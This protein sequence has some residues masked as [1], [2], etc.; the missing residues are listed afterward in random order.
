MVDCPVSKS[1]D[2]FALITALTLV[3]L[4]VLLLTSMVALVRTQQRTNELDLASME[5]R[6]NAY[7]A[8][9]IAVAALQKHAGPDQRIT[10]PATAVLPSKTVNQGSGPL[11]DDGAFGYRS[12]ARTSNSRSYLAS[13]ETY[14]T[15]DERAAWDSAV[16]DW[17]NDNDFQP[18][19]TA[20]F[21]SGRR[22]DRATDPL[23]DPVA[24]PDER[25]EAGGVTRY[26]AFNRDQPPVWLVSG[27][28]RLGYDP[29]TDTDHPN[30]YRTPDSTIPDPGTDAANPTV[31][32]VGDASATR[33]RD[34]HDGLDGRVKVP[35]VDIP[36]GEAGDRTGRY[37]FWVGDESIKANF[38]VHAEDPSGLGTGSPAYRN[39]LQVP[40]R[41][42]WERMEGFA[43][44]NLDPYADT[45]R[46]VRAREHIRMLDTGFGDDP[47]TPAVNE[48]V[49]ARNFHAI[50]AH[51]QSLL[52]DAALGGL[53]RDLTRYL[54][55]GD[56]LNDD[57]PIAD[58]GR[59]T[60][61]DPRFAAWGGNNNGF[62]NSTDA[63]LDGI[64][65]WGR[66]REWFQ[67]EAT[68]GGSIAPDADSGVGPVI[69]Y[70][71][72]N[73]GWSY[74]G[75]SQTIRWHWMP[76]VVLW[77]PYDV[78]L[79]Q[80][81][82]D[83]DLRINPILT[84]TLV[85]NPDPALADVQT[86]TG[87]GWQ[88]DPDPSIDANGDGDPANDW[89]FT[90]T[91]NNPGQPRL[92]A[93]NPDATDVSNGPWVA[94]ADPADG[95]TDAYGRLYYA[96][97]VA[98]PATMWGDNRPI[99][100]NPPFGPLG[101]RAFALRFVPH[102]P[103]PETRSGDGEI[104]RV[105]QLR[106]NAGFEAGQAK[107]FTLAS[108]GEWVPGSRQA[109]VNDFDP[110]FPVDTWFDVIRVMDGPPSAEAAG[111]RWFA[112]DLAGNRGQ[113]APAVRLA[114]AGGGTLFFTR[115]FGN[116]ETDDAW[117]AAQGRDYREVAG[118][119]PE[120]NADADGD[121]I[122][123][124]DENNPK[125]V[126][127]WRPL[128]DFA[129]FENHLDTQ[130]GSRRLAANWAYG[131]T[132]LQPLTGDGDA[133]EEEVHHYQ[134][135]LSRFNYAAAFY[136]EHPLVEAMRSRNDENNYEASGIYASGNRGN[137]GLI[138]LMTVQ[139]KDDEQFGNFNE[140]KWDENQADFTDGF[141]LITFQN[142]EF[143]AGSS[144]IGL[145]RIAVRN[146][147][148][149]ESNLLSLGQLQQVNLS[150]Y[151]WQPAN[152]IG[153]SWASPYVDRE[154]IAGLH[155]RPVGTQNSGS[156][157]Q[158]W[159]I[160]FPGPGTIAN[161]ARGDGRPH[162]PGSGSQMEEDPVTGIVSYISGNGQRAN[163]FTPGNTL[164]DLSYLLNENLW[165]RYFLSA[166]PASPDPR[167]ALPNGRLRYTPAAANA[168]PGDLA[169]FETAAA[170]LRNVGALNVNA[171]SVE[172]WKALL[173]AFRDLSLANNPADTVPVVRSLDPIGEPITFTFDAER[174]AT[175]EANEI[176]AVPAGK[177]YTRVMSGFRYLS[178]GMI[179]ALAERIV[180]EVRL[181]GPFYS[182]ADFVNR[183]LVPPDGSNTPGSDWYAA[184]THGNVGGI[185]DNHPDFISGGYRP[186]IGLQG[187]SGTLQRA[188]QVSGING[189]LNHPRFSD[190]DWVYTPR[191]KSSG[192]MDHQD[193]HFSANGITGNL[194]PKHT[195]MPSMRSHVDT[196]HLAGAPVGE[197]GQLFDGAPGF[198]TQGDLL[199]MLA[200][201]LTPRGDTFLVRTYG[202]S[203]NP[204]TGEIRSRAW[205]E[206]VVQRVARPVTPAA[207]SGPDRW[208]YTDRFGR[209][210]EI[211]EIRWL[212]RDE[213]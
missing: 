133:D 27:N 130:N 49:T 166:G 71:M 21:D 121:G 59:Y 16:K 37:G 6:A 25:Y 101:D 65:S 7:L 134:A 116:L 14:L 154:A 137:E 30:G 132:W 89:L 36:P 8:L 207:A 46:R 135:V 200:P 120:G 188:I 110:D 53:R 24:L 35:L 17:W 139:H 62:P 47:T 29:L 129:S 208:R 145:D 9:K 190:A 202:D 45:F 79:D 3:G 33:A 95:L 67:N 169:G 94:D 99:S 106:I 48:S 13:A 70:V 11:Y 81:A 82:Y 124:R 161:N 156:T 66:I 199:A 172:A 58:P 126:P 38:A 85:V 196:E 209:Q 122:V 34:S 112:Q 115:K 204:A 148:R 175:I 63:A 96:L 201:A 68:G 195:Q 179:Q 206:A 131:R 22:Q 141:A 61:N 181:R 173:T 90:D 18:H 192:G 75:P 44:A 174:N 157:D 1:R 163:F 86:Q 150:A 138:K 74:H 164:L 158:P 170:Y 51:S 54:E 143:V 105:L 149:A 69:T 2:G 151:Y 52:T 186:F 159:N 10:A 183:R 165:D 87:A 64:P 39:Y 19:W 152:P 50:T 184:R 210:F 144:L 20:V 125:F 189:G 41:I 26:G 92:P 142:E 104:E 57:D 114:L 197:A 84:D 40:Q 182:L 191:I 100:R 171:T 155:S 15:P 153:N 177:D 28:E 118:F 119:G 162:S 198:V 80:T 103:D 167:T 43:D 146:A 88:P 31:W 187:L 97:E 4:L 193:T 23:G 42:G 73:G 117:K 185:N 78:P 127:R 111:L 93:A 60:D 77:N 128:Y 123:N 178:D 203:L 102:D 55:D 205:L 12:F 109:M 76:C 147:R 211:M 72:F 168:D 212:S 91:D 5:A 108:G 136:D 194:D 113:T 160:P 180:D 107:V 176:G 140:V 32:L 98:D 213:I 56:G 83:L